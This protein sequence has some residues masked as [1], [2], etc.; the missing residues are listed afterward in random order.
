MVNEGLYGFSPVLTA[1][2]VG[3]IFL[4]PSPK[5]TLYALLATVMT[6][7]GRMIMLMM[8][9]VVGPRQTKLLLV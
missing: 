1:L 9:L 2:A 8:L 3:V 4:K 5:V 7:I 6:W